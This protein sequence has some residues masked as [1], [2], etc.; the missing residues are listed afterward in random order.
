MAQYIFPLSERIRF[1]GNDVVGFSSEDKNPIP[2]DVLNGTCNAQRTSQ[3]PIRKISPGTFTE[4]NTYGFRSLNE[5]R[6]YSLKV[7]FNYEGT[8]SIKYFWIL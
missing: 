6:V 4:G 7:T 5:C 1:E 3:S 2:Y 8:Y